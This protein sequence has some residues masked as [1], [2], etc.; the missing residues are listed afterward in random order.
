MSGMKGISLSFLLATWEGGGSVGPALTVARKL[1]DRGHRVR[2]MSDACN[3]PEAEAAGATFVPWTRAPSRGDRSKHSDVFRDWEVDTPQQQIQ[4]VLDRIMTGPALAY[5]QDVIEELDREP[6]D[7]VVS[8]EM[9]FGVMAGCESVGQRFALLTCNIS[10]FPLEGVPPMGPGLAPAANAAEEA[11][12]CEV[13]EANRLMFDGGLRAL[14]QARA[15]LGLRPL[16]ALD[17]QHRAA[18]RLLLGTSR[19]FDFAPPT[20]AP[21]IRYVGPQL[22][23]PA[24]AAPWHSP[25]PAEDM[26]PLILVGFSTSFQDHVGVLQTIIDAAAELPVRLLVT[27]GA[28]I[29]PDELSPAPNSRLV[30]SAPHN[31]VM[32]GAALVITHGGHG[33]VV[34]AL[35]HGKPMIIVPH[36]RDQNDN[37]V[38]VTAREAGLKLAADAPAETF[39]SAIEALLSDPRYAAGAEA[40]GRRVAD[41][42]EH[43]PVVEELESLAAGSCEATDLEAA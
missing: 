26:R 10:L 18:E 4:R 14:N 31:E 43:S 20:L 3:R 16:A 7:L 23:D 35:V 27:L 30:P 34:R 11:L 38:R 17:D 22:D 37:A 21:H 12:H 32:P 5:A 33:T 25:W 8:S 6:A 42:T 13:A 36:G 9:L 24:W 40:L 29:S 15:A 41:E 28:T 1:V 19:A 2:V 39:R